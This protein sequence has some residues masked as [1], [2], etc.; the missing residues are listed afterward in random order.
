[1]L[2]FTIV[3]GEFIVFLPFSI[4]IVFTRARQSSTCHRYAFAA[5][6]QHNDLYSTAVPASHRERPHP[7]LVNT[8]AS[9]WLVFLFFKRRGNFVNPEIKAG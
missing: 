9:L 1:M 6:A 8:L 5:F 4:G 7:L 3:A 2:R